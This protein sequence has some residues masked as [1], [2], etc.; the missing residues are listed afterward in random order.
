MVLVM[1]QLRPGQIYLTLIRTIS[2]KPHTYKPIYI[3]YIFRGKGWYWW[4]GRM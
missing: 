1:E 4:V 3:L 2:L